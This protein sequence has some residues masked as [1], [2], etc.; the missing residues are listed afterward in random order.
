MKKKPLMIKPKKPL[1]QD[2]PEIDEES[3]PQGDSIADL[4]NKAVNENNEAVRDIFSGK[5]VKNKTDLSDRKIILVTKGLYLAKRFNLPK[6]HEV[7]N[8]YLE[9]RIS[10]NRGSRKEYIE[11]LKA[12]IEQQMMQGAMQNRQNVMR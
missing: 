8:N 10:K 6:L 1:P 9:L 11:G 7:I 12:K 3:I 4:L 2:I 5:D